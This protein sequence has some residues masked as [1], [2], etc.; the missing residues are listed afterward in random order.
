M[1]HSLW[2]LARLAIPAGEL[3]PWWLLV[4]RA[5]LFPLDFFY[6][7]MSLRQ[8]YQVENNTWLI[9]GVRYSGNA[10]RSLADAE[11]EIFRISRNGETMTIER[12]GGAS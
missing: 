4:I 5:I 7:R 6:W 1:R 3:L 11:G 12:V 10:L 8:G 9:H 2:H